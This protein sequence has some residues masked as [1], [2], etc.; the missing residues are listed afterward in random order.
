MYVEYLRCGWCVDNICYLISC[1]VEASFV[2]GSSSWGVG[3]AWTHSSVRL[4]TSMT[5]LLLEALGL[6]EYTPPWGFGPQWLSPLTMWWWLT[7]PVVWVLV[8]CWTHRAFVWSWW[9]VEIRKHVWIW[10]VF[11]LFWSILLIVYFFATGG[12]GTG[13]WCWVL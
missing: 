5:I 9:M 7:L 3:P 4:L 10:R 13:V 12:F 6:H 11:R 1:S 8:S 2:D